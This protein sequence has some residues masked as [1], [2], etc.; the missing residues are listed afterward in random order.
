MVMADRIVIL[1]A[2]RIEQEGAP[3]DVYNNPVTPFVARFM[4]AENAIELPAELTA[5]RIEIPAGPHNAAATLRPRTEAPDSVAWPVRTHTVT[6]YFRSEAAELVEP[7]QTRPNPR[8]QILLTGH[9]TH[10]SYPGGT[11]RHTVKVG[12]QDFHVDS[13]VRHDTSAPVLV[14]LPAEAVFVFPNEQPP[15]NREHEEKLEA[16]RA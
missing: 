14:R 2:G 16:Q 11:W 6:A 13:S 5:D 1:N 7:D 3:E 15:Q 4:G 12:E 8:G 9:V 10:V